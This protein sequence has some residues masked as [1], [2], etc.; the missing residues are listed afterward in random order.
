MLISGRV[1]LHK[2]I[3]SVSASEFLVSLAASIG[4]LLNLGSEGVSWAIA[5]ALLAGGAI[6]APFAAWLVRKV[7]PRILGAGVGGLIV[8]TNARTMLN[9]FQVDGPGRTL[10][11]LVLFALWGGAL[12]IAIGRHRREREEIEAESVGV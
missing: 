12:A 11:Y 4:F 3:G 6:A 1:E 5:G 9:E 8:V 2:V 10:T 7:A